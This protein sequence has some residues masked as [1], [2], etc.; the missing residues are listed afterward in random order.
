[1]R[2]QIEKY[3]V[4]VC[5]SQLRWG[6]P[7]QDAIG[8][9]LPG[10]VILGRQQQSGQELNRTKSLVGMGHELGRA[11]TGSSSWSRETRESTSLFET[12]LRVD[13]IPRFMPP[14]QLQEEQ[15]RRVAYVLTAPYH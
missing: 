1:M 15:L 8:T 11:R 4:L 13:D 3:E 14:S 2:C 10:T 5:A 7:S 6:L 9:L 12:T